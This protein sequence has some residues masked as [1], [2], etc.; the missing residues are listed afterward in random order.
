MLSLHSTIAVCTKTRYR[1]EMSM[2]GSSVR[3]GIAELSLC[4][5]APD[6]RWRWDD[7]LCRAWWIDGNGTD[8]AIAQIEVDGSWSRV[9]RESFRAVN[10]DSPREHRRRPRN[11][12]CCS[13]V[14]I[15]VDSPFTIYRGR[16]SI[17][18]RASAQL[19]FQLDCTL[20]TWSKND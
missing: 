5:T 14:E 2:M 6:K 4:I 7:K 13:P 1:S 12:P 18:L 9:G 15:G 17:F 8:W 20:A 3:L 19:Y 16:W 10:V 11:P